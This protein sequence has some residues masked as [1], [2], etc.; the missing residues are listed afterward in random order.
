MRL[1]SVT[2][3]NYRSITRAHKIALVDS[4]V[5]VGPNNE[6]KSN[7]LKALVIAMEVLTSATQIKIHGQFYTTRYMSGS[8]YKW[9][10]DFPISLQTK[11]PAGKSTFQLEF[12]LSTHEIDEFKEETQSKLNGTLPIR[13]EI[14][15]DNN[16]VITVRK[17]GPGG[18]ALTK[19]SADIGYFLAKRVQFQYIPAVRTASSAQQVVDRMI[20][21]ELRTL[22]E[23]QEYKEA[24]QKITDLQKPVLSKISSN[25]QTTMVDFLPSIKSVR[26]E[27]ESEQRSRALRRTKMYVDDGTPTLLEHKEFKA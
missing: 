10:N 27:I 21:K 24:I 6:G 8:N 9:K 5:L 16:P 19:K 26:V 2:V 20:D 1:V 14:G 13:I 12:E 23:S 15:P 25:M 7:F 18:A 22:E 11:Q 3:T 4:T 17:K